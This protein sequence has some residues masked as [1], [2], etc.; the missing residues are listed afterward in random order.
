MESEVC[1][2]FQHADWNSCDNLETLAE[3]RSKEKNRWK[4]KF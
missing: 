3:T 1:R 2:S 4:R